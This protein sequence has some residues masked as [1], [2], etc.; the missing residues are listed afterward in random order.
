M[1]K[2]NTLESIHQFLVSEI[3]RVTTIPADQIDSSASLPDIGVDSLSV[4][5]IAH[6]IECRFE[7]EVSPVDFFKHPNPKDLAAVIHG[8]LNNEL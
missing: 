1:S 5:E 2:T 3:S 8:K 7:V 6:A 4:M